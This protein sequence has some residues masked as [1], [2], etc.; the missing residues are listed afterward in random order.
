[1]DP[2]AFQLGP[3]TVYWYGVLIATGV[4]AGFFVARHLGRKFNLPREI[5][6]EFLLFTLPAA[7]VGARLWYVLFKLDYYLADP[8]RILAIRQGGLAIH[9]AVLASLTVA[10]FF[11]RCRKIDFYR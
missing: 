8:V 9:G 10:I 7:L 3:L 1:M 2:V 5:F 4:A 6:E 11:C